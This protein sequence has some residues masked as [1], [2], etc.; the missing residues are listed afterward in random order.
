M[1][2]GGAA[3]AL[4]WR[5]WAVCEVVGGCGGLWWWMGNY[6]GLGLMRARG[7]RGGGSWGWRRRGSGRVLL[8]W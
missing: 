2:W 7:S 3:R 8:V 6:G 4:R 1:R 5:T